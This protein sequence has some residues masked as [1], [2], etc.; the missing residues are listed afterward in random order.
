[1][2]RMPQL[3]SR[4][5]VCGLIAGALTLA[6]ATAGQAKGATVSASRAAPPRLYVAL[7]DSY[8][9][10]SLIP[11]QV[12][13][14]ADCFR[15]DRNY[16]SLT[17]QALGLTL[18]DV[19]CSGAATVHTTAPQAGLL[20]GG[21]NPPQLD[22]VTP[23]TELVTVQIG[24]NDTGI[25]ALAA[26]CVLAGAIAPTGSACRASNSS[27]GRD[28][29]RE[30]IAAA[31]PKIAAVLRGIH[32]R[33]PSARVA[34][35]GYPAIAPTDGTNCYSLVPLSPDDVAYVNELFVAMNAMLAE[36]AAAN[37]AEYVDTYTSTVGHHFCA[38]PETR[39]FEGPL[40]SDIAYPYHPNARGEAAMARSAIA[41][42]SLPRPQPGPVLS[43]LRQQRSARRAG[44][45]PR[46]SFTLDRRAT[47]TFTL[48][49]RVATKR[50]GPLTHT[51]SRTLDAGTARIELP[52]RLLGRRPGTYKLTATPAVAD[53][54]GALVAV[55]FR[56]R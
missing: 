36:Q 44:R 18:R 30:R 13:T 2:S 11:N 34:L 48:R 56:I 29:V 46:F 37:D 54:T 47:V 20:L 15:S 39:W 9:A 35:V 43:A 6:T 8:T 5:L 26:N 14:P 51:F 45:P 24:A 22:G 3:S 53:L 49:R 33:A 12:G 28:L 23:D 50:Y 1:M 7:G 40:P 17:A 32:Q 21:T 41:V 42:L 52:P 38:L 55:R 19:S 27:G 31:A 25:V 16:P 4:P 10:G